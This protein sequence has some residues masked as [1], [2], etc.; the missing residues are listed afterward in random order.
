MRPCVAMS[1]R[2]PLAKRRSARAGA[3]PP[4]P[5]PIP[6]EEPVGGP[7]LVIA[8]SLER[9]LTALLAHRD[10]L[11][12]MLVMPAPSPLLPPTVVR[13]PDEAG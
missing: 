9:D 12:R 2:A 11:E 10:E 8:E 1:R 5:A 4:D 13:S 6:P 3:G 7:W